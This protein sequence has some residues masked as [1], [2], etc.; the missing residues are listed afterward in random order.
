MSVDT[1]NEE[2]MIP[3]TIV[4]YGLPGPQASS[5]TAALL[6]NPLF[7]VRGVFSKE[8]PQMDKFKE[9]GVECEVMEITDKS[10]ISVT[11]LRHIFREAYGAFIVTN[12]ADPPLAMRREMEVGIRFAEFFQRLELK[13]VIYST[14]DYVY[15][16]TGNRCPRYDGKGEIENEMRAR[17]LPL[18]VLKLPLSYE[19]LCNTFIPQRMGHE[20]VCSMTTESNLSFDAMN[21]SDVG[22]VVAVAF[23]RPNVFI[24]KTIGLTVDS[25]CLDTYVELLNQYFRTE[26]CKFT[27][28]K[29][30][31]REYQKNKKN[32]RELATIL[33]FHCN[34]APLRDPRT[35]IALNPHVQTFM[36]YIEANKSRLHK[37]FKLPVT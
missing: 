9:M 18:T 26:T 31:N 6:G 11:K 5:V 10:T 7:T 25:I 29:T 20:Y 21:Y 8:C 22:P 17:E 34:Y 36:E 2:E 32:N 15:R 14:M 1:D 30:T 16:I 13:H 23:E 35:T 24:G 37:L 12:D 3:K 4:V 27:Y 33:D 19:Y 28:E